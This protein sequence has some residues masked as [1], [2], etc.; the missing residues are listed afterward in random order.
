MV[1]SITVDSNLKKNLLKPEIYEAKNTLLFFSRPIRSVE[2]G[3]AAP[4]MRST[5]RPLCGPEHRPPPRVLRW[6]EECFFP[7][8]CG[9]AGRKASRPTPCPSLSPRRL[10]GVA[11]RPA[12]HTHSGLSGTGREKTG[13]GSGCFPPGRVLLFLHSLQ[14]KSGS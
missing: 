4:R 12:M 5:S 14:A 1:I 7:G 13:G 6:V 2:C 3:G 8:G 11:W 10:R 9:P